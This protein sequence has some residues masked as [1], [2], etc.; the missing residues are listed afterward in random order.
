MPEE[1]SIEARASRFTQVLDAAAKLLGVRID[2]AAYLRAALNRHCSE[3]QIE[4]AVAETPAAAGIPVEVIT[5]AAN[6]SITFET[7]KATAL[8]AVA[9]VPGGLALVGTIPA[10]LIQYFGH[11]LRIA[12]KLAY[13][14]SW[15]DLFTDD[16]D[17]LDDATEGILTLFVGVMFGVQVAQG[18][19]T[20]VSI[21]IAEQVAKKLPQQALTNG[22]IYPVV[23]KVASY[24]GVSMTK[25]LFAGGIAKIIPVAGAL[26]SGGL[27]L[28]TFLPMS[29]KLQRHLASLELTK[30]GHRLDEAQIIDVVDLDN[31]LHSEV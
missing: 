30:P 19:V 29:K 12:Q 16:G 31:S 11:V 4:R 5:A 23:K 20:K 21:M 10:D 15:P 22:A 14:Y 9:G 24:L 2:R 28:A 6:E 25:R 13:I 18:G 26:L 1:K 7:A 8:S 3:D 27:T 17:E